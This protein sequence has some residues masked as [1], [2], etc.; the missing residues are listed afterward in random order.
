ME[1][2]FDVFVQINNKMM[3][4]YK[5]TENIQVYIMLEEFIFQ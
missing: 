5:R 3:N 4:I 1:K 2:H